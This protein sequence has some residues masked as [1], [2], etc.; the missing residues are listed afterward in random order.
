MI[1]DTPTGP[2]VVN[3]EN[4]GFTVSHEDAFDGQ[5]GNLT[6]M[7]RINFESNNGH[8]CHLWAYCTV[9]VIEQDGDYPRLEPIQGYGASIIDYEAPEI[10]GQKRT[11][12]FEIHE[13]DEAE[14][15]RDLYPHLCSKLDQEHK[16]NLEADYR[17][18]AL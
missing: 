11:K 2:T 7:A 18:G 14:I 1:I 6:I 8:Q 9:R 17:E 10:N 4:T 15:V 16:I 3:P 12:E 5:P 13:E